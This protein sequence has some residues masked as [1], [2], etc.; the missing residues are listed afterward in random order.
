MKQLKRLS[1]MELLRIFS[2]LFIIISHLNIYGINWGGKSVPIEDNICLYNIGGVIAP[3]C[4]IGVN[5]FF[6]LSGYFSIKHNW[7]KWI[8]IIITVYI[9][10]NHSGHR[11]MYRL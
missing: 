9:Y 2:M 3:F 10:D 6:L 11:L 8:N 7:K 4:V 1:S 5:L